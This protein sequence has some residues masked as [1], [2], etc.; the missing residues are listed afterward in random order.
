MFCASVTY[1]VDT[2]RFDLEYSATR[3]APMFAQLLGENCLRWEVHRP[4]AAP[5]SP[6]PPFRAAA[7][8]WVSSGEDF[9]RTLAEHGPAIYAGIAEFSEAQPIRGWSE[10]L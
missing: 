1:P 5:G 6:P 3:D 9:G 7:Y 2:G 10:V 8:F 4:L